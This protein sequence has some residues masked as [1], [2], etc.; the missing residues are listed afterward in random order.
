MNKKNSSLASKYYSIYT[1]NFLRNAL[2]RQLPTSQAK[3]HLNLLRQLSKVLS[4]PFFPIF[5]LP[6]KRMTKPPLCHILKKGN[7]AIPSTGWCIVWVPLLIHRCVLL[8]WW[9]TYCIKK[10]QLFQFSLILSWILSLSHFL[11]HLKHL[12]TALSQLQVEMVKAIY[13]KD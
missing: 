11:I 5:L 12:E 6:K 4:R 13:L 10:Q 7:W 8:F 9:G 2:E 3:H 1:L